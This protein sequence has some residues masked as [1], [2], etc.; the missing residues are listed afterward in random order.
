MFAQIEG[1]GGGE[2]LIEFDQNFASLL[3][4]YEKKINEKMLFINY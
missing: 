4:I 1:G 3:S 2:G